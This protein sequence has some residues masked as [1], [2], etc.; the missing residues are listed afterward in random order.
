MNLSTRAKRAAVAAGSLFLRLRG[1]ALTKRFERSLADPEQAQERTLRRIL[2]S[3]RSTDYGKSM[4]ITGAETPA[5]FQDKVSPQSYGDLPAEFAP[6]KILFYEKT[7]GSSGAAKYIPYNQ[8]LKNAFNDAFLLWVCD[9]LNQN[10]GFRTGRLFM[11][12]SPSLRSETRTEDGIPVG[13][14]DDA[15]YLSGPLSLLLRPFLVVPRSLNGVRNPEVFRK[16]L[17]AC[18]LA[19]RDLEIISIWSPTYLQVLLEY[20][21][22]NRESLVALLKKGSFA[23]EGRVFAF[24]RPSPEREAELLQSSLGWER[25]WPGLRLIS[26][27]TSAAA[28][29][30]ALTLKRQFPGVWVQGKGLLA[31]EAPMTIPWSPAGACVPLLDGV[32]IEVHREGEAA[33]VP[34]YELQEG[35]VGEIVLTQGAGLLRY[36]MGDSVRVTGRYKRTPCLE[37]LGRS[38]ASCD[39][40][41]EKLSE[42]FAEQS[43]DAL[44]MVDGGARLLVPVRGPADRSRYVLL[45]EKA[46]SSEE[47]RRLARCYELR[48]QES[49]HYG[50]SRRLA[51]LLPLAT[52]TVPDLPKR[53]QEYQSARGLAWGDIKPQFLLR[54]IVTRYEL[55]RWFPGLSADREDLASME[56]L[57]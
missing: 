9:I 3:I 52:R 55:D 8:A 2:R 25:V 14:E 40:T 20:I 41:G 12:V 24:P 37:F 13:L 27:W 21:Q 6:G 56:V 19:E 49:Y 26:C 48:L 57:R 22:A 34:L 42:R 30:P 53:Y 51:Q 54:D 47:Q 7:S 15:A 50:Y 23:A 16:V 32:F 35:D 1:K 17:S 44:R 33:P 45:I 31:T 4:G 10:P 5:Q 28:E 36:R 43:L 38:D 46:V 39:M 29:E 11:S 18:L